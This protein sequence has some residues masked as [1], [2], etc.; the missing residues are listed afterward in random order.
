[1]LAGAMCGRIEG[2]FV[3]E[4]IAPAAGSPPRPFPME[5]KLGGGGG[6]KKHH[7]EA[8]VDGTSVRLHS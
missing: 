6:K 1:M 2:T 7:K 4:Y 5:E 3:S 8:H